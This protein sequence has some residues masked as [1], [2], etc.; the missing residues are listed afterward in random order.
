MKIFYDL[1]KMD[2][3]NKFLEKRQ[4]KN[5][6]NIK[7]KNR[8]YTITK[9][10]VKIIRAY[11]SSKCL[12]SSIKS[13]PNRIIKQETLEPI[14]RVKVDKSEL[15][16]RN[17]IKRR[18]SYP[19]KK[20]IKSP[21]NEVMDIWEDDGLDGLKNYIQEWT[22]SINTPYEGP[23]EDLIF[24]KEDLESELK[25]VYMNQFRPRDTR[26]KHIRDIIPSLPDVESLR[27]F[28]EYPSYKYKYSG[29]PFLFNN[30]LSTTINGKLTVKDLK[31]DK[32]LV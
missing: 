26:S 4:V 31:F 23:V 24:R 19:I 29:K 3:I 28:P 9:E 8:K 25:R 5:Q 7:Y 30:I 15:Y 16:N 18:A 17:F 27:P 6:K 21:V 10:D 20:V 13:I 11:K 32:I 1:L 14:I 22:Y 12:D 2:R